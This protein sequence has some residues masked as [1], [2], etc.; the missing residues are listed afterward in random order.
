MAHQDVTYEF[1]ER[2]VI[3]EVPIPPTPVVNNRGDPLVDDHQQQVMAN[4]LFICTGTVKLDFK[5]PG[6][7]PDEG[8]VIFPILDTDFLQLALHSTAVAGPPWGS[9][10]KGHT[11]S[12]RCPC[13]AWRDQKRVVTLVRGDAPLEPS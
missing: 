6:Y 7:T 12:S 10:F 5:A 11:H 9:S 13:I 1:V 8:T 4:R 3:I 2:P